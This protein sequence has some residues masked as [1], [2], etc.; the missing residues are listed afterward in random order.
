[1]HVLCECPGM[2][3]NVRWDD[4]SVFT[5][6]T[7]QIKVARTKRER[8]ARH[9]RE[10]EASAA[11]SLLFNRAWRKHGRAECDSGLPAFRRSRP[12]ALRSIPSMAGT[13]FREGVPPKPWALHHPVRA[14]ICEEP[15]RSSHIAAIFFSPPVRS[16]LDASL[17]NMFAYM[18]DA[19]IIPSFE[20]PSS[21]TGS[22]AYRRARVP[23]NIL[24]PEYRESFVTQGKMARHHATF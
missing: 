9:V 20:V 16:I 12:R 1:M 23:K 7:M 14:F 2:A 11:G 8:P 21:S 24:S 5:L 3:C 4:H 18:R 15:P 19:R 6:S 13:L 17:A 22:H 10:G